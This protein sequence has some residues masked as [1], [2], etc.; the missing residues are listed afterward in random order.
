[1]PVQIGET[2][3]QAALHE[4][5][6]FGL[7]Q[8]RACVFAGSFFVIL[9]ASKH[10]P[11]GSMPRYDFIFLAAVALQIALVAM[12]IETLDELKVI[13]VFHVI[14]LALEIFKTDPRIGE[15]SYPEASFF[16]IRAVPLYSGF[17]YA[18]V[19]SYMC[20]AWRLLKLDLTGYPPYA[21]SVPLSAA[22]YANFFTRHFLPDV[23]WVLAAL[24]IIIF[25]KARVWFTVTEKR[26]FMPIALSFFLIGLFVWLAENISTYLGAYLYPNQ[27]GGWQHVAFRRV[28]SWFLLVIISFMIVA[29][30]KHLK[31]RL[32][33]QAPTDRCG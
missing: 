12:R 14:G 21:L 11:L 2:E 16:R 13:C 24:V 32:K 5:W 3:V 26:R 29:D 17:M 25:W 8:A 23:R 6:W 15:W 27:Q 4:F 28:S 1:M 22:I 33:R 19:A 20:Q 7:K 10:I 31:E 18:S 9:F 30:L